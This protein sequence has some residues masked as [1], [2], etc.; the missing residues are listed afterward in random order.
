MANSFGNTLTSSASLN[1]AEA[2]NE[3][4]RKYIRQRVTEVL[5]ADKLELSKRAVDAGASARTIIDRNV[6]KLEQELN[7]YL[8]HHMDEI[9]ARRYELLHISELEVN[10]TAPGY[11]NGK[12]IAEIQRAVI[13]KR[14]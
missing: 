7:D 14:A 10:S 8:D 12:I 13:F 6:R 1:T 5:T 11:R 9:V 3:A 4:Y 2:R